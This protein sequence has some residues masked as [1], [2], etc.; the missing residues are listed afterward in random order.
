[1]HQSKFSNPAIV[2]DYFMGRILFLKRDFAGSLE[3][4]QKVVTAQG[5]NPS[6]A[7]RTLAAECLVW[8]RQI[9]SHQAVNER[10]K[11][12]QEELKDQPAT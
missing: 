1:M 3:R 10:L 7:G 8:Q 9:L 11:A 5:T 2:A 6:D 4:F 12:A